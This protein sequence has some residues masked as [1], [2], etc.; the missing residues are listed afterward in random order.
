MTS[1]GVLNTYSVATIPSHQFDSM[2]ISAS[3]SANKPTPGT[4]KSW[5]DP[6]TF[7]VNEPMP[8]TA[9]LHSFFINAYAPNTKL[10][11]DVCLATN[12]VH[13]YNLITSPDQFIEK[14]TDS[15]VAFMN[16]IV[17]GAW[18][19]MKSAAN[20]R[21]AITGRV[22][23]VKSTVNATPYHYKHMSEFIKLLIPDELIGRH[24]PYEMDEVSA[25]QPSPTQQAKYNN[26]MNSGFYHKRVSKDFLKSECYQK[27]GDPRLISTGN[28]LDKIEYSAFVYPVSDHLKTFKWY[29]F[30]HTPL[31]IARRVAYVCS[32]A[33]SFVIPSDMSRWD[34]R[35][36][37]VLRTLEEMVMTRMYPSMYHDQLHDLM[38]GQFNINGY[39]PQG[40]SYRKETCRSSGSPETSAFNTI[41][42][43]F[44]AY[45]TFR[46]MG[47]STEASF[48]R[49]GV[50][51]GDDGLTADIDLVKYTKT[52]ENY[53]QKLTSEVIEF[54]K[55]GVNFLSRFFGPE[56][57]G[58]DPNSCCDIRRM[59]S[60]FHCH[61]VSHKDFPKV[62]LLQKVTSLGLTDYATPIFN[63]IIKTVT[64][65]DNS[66][67]LPDY[68]R[69]WDQFDPSVQWPNVTADFMFELAH[70][71][72][73]EF[74]YDLFHDFCDNCTTIEEFLKFPTCCVLDP[75]IKEMDRLVEMDGDI[76]N[77]ES[78]PVHDNIDPI[79]PDLK[80]TTEHFVKEQASPPLSPRHWSGDIAENPLVVNNKSTFS[81][82][83]KT[84]NGP[85]KHRSK[86]NSRSKTTTR[87]SKKSQTTI[88]NDEEI[89]LKGKSQK[90][91]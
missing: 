42:N 36:S 82:D 57:W 54:G 31:E 87:S 63:T 7:T 60:K 43:A 62:K 17:D 35:V 67:V 5:L 40:T 34:G 73:P 90:G 69:W 89:R 9:A 55:P 39:C 11:N 64:R 78:P 45:A 14:K 53:G 76:H 88:K 72:L 27:L 61:S 8:T 33:T 71:Q 84:T 26:A 56:V 2:M 65:L 50:Y 66:T 86:N 41:E 21:A 28:D 80:Y 25:R 32:T 20:E 58:G 10:V 83:A 18:S 47:L 85:I 15:M 24:H 51:G 6:K 12:A 79:K 91:G 16:P 37:P 19:P 1:V 23:N 13:S 74:D 46:H 77:M 52:V 59:I 75:Q 48:E 22:T 49:L 44:L 3:L 38:S 30:G 68:E 70:E 4:F 81:F 29:A